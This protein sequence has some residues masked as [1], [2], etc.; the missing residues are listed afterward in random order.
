MLLS[1]VRIVAVEEIWL[2]TKIDRQGAIVILGAQRE[3]P[4]R[5]RRI[6]R[7]AMGTFEGGSTPQSVRSPS[8]PFLS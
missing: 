4:W 7:F 3:V 5:T 6:G 8:S 2:A 1:L